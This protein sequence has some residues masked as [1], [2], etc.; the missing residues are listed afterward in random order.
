MCAIPQLVPA[1]YI[2]IYI[3]KTSHKHP[4]CVDVFF[5]KQYIKNK[6]NEDKTHCKDHLYFDQFGHPVK[7]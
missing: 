5:I 7:I 4:M 1:P 2:Y 3:Y 6:I